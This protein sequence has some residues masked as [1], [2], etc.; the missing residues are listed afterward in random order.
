MV[1]KAGTTGVLF[2]RQIE[3]SALLL[4]LLHS[5]KKLSAVSLTFGGFAQQGRDRRAV[6]L[7]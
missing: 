6:C 3:G 5:A 7:L 4:L 2:R 1:D